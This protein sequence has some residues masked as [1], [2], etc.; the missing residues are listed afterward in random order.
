MRVCVQ[1]VFD[2]DKNTKTLTLIEHADG[3]SVDTIKA[4]TQAPFKISPQ[5]T[6]MSL[7]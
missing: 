6:K 7:A 5:L 1:A 3:V 4:K 2:V